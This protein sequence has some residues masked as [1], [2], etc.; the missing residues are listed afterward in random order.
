MHRI[1]QTLPC[2]YTQLTLPRRA[3]LPTSQTEILLSSTSRPTF[4]CC[5]HSFS[6][7]S[8]GARSAINC[9]LNPFENAST[10]PFSLATT[11]MSA[12]PPT[13]GHSAACCNIPPVVSQGYEKKGS[14][15]D[16]G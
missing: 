5:L 2:R 14:Y 4:L 16:I 13:A 15:E 12:M 3:P 1:R 6:A 9:T 11:K 8:L 7:T 10:R